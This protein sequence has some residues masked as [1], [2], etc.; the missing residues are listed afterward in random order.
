MHKSP[1]IPLEISVRFLESSSPKLV[2]ELTERVLLC[3]SGTGVFVLICFIPLKWDWLN[4]WFMK[5][6]LMGMVGY[7]NTSVI[8]LLI[9]A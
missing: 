5:P 8:R 3:C 2:T 7:V 9:D 6:F 1:L 4:V